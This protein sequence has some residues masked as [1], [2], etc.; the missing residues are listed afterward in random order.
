MFSV[1]NGLSYKARGYSM[2]GILENIQASGLCLAWPKTEVL[3]G[4]AGLL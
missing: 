4:R 2:N 3:F 1:M